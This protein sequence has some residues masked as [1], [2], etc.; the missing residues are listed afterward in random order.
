MYISY[1]N[2]WKLLADKGITKHELG[3]L[4]GMSTRTI[5]K[6]AKNE[7][8]TT[9]TLLRV[10]EVL[11]CGIGDIMEVTAEEKKLSLYEAFR[12][13]AVQIAEDENVITFRLEYE[14][15]ICIIKKTK[16]T[17][18][19]RT[20]I[21]CANDFAIW[22]QVHYSNVIYMVPGNTEKTVIATRGFFK[23]DEVGILVITG[24]PKEIAGLD[25]GGFV[26]ASRERKAGDLA[27]MT[28]AEF[29]DYSI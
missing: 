14:G 1:D 24:C 19:K 28:L 13:N 15:K 4:T 21:H 17:A 16:K 12:K 26:S 23:K 18:G 25:D 8:V 20:F 2:L 10:C 27:V 5:S 3:E 9:D 7:T 22:C 29:R 11:G 6:L